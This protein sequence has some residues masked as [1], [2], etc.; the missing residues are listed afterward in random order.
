[1]IQFTAL[2]TV[3]ISTRPSTNISGHMVMY[4]LKTHGC[5]SVVEKNAR[6][7]TYLKEVKSC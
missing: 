6:M 2:D 1:M 3:L 5:V 7:Y 4:Q